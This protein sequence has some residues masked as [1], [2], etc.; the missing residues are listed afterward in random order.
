MVQM[1]EECLTC[2]NVV[3]HDRGV[4]FRERRF[5]DLYCFLEGPVRSP[6]VPVN[7]R[8][9]GVHVLLVDDNE[10]TLELFRAALEYCGA[11][12]TTADALDGEAI[13]RQISP[14]VLVSDIAMPYDGL[15]TMRQVRL[16]SAKTSRV[17]PEIAISGSRRDRHHLREAGFAAF[18]PKPLD[19]FVLADVVAKLYG[20][21][22]GTD[23]S[24]HP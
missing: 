10:S 21:R 19:P 11:L 17:I 14:H 18:L 13:L 12:V 15:E 4:V 20:E 23:N 1:R 6:S 8:L 22:S 7:Q 24:R 3:P 5:V 9:L 16:F 2:G